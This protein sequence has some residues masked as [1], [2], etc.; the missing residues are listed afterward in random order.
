MYPAFK[1]SRDVIDIPASVL[2]MAEHGRII[3]AARTGY[4]SLEKIEMKNGVGVNE[5]V[6]D[7]F[8]N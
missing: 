6:V 3:I 1:R 2:A 4:Y 7:E 5:V 8:N